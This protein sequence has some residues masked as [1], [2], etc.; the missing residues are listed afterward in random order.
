MAAVFVRLGAR[1]LR[2]GRSPALRAQRRPGGQFLL[3]QRNAPAQRGDLLPAK[4]HREQIARP[5][6][7]PLGAVQFAFFV[8]ELPAGPGGRDDPQV[9]KTGE[10][11]TIVTPG[12]D[13]S[14]RRVHRPPVFPAGA[15]RCGPLSPAR[16]PQHP[17]GEPEGRGYKTEPTKGRST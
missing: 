6:P 16:G 11:R 3:E 14:P 2:A 15:V 5:V 10:N 12:A 8:A 1:A 4:V 7:D 17:N 13:L 9:L